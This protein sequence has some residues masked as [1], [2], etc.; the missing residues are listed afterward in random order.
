MY[1]GSS[2]SLCLTATQ[3]VPLL[4]DRLVSRVSAAVLHITLSRPLL[5]LAAAEQGCHFWKVSSCLS[6]TNQSTL[7]WDNPLPKDFHF[8]RISYTLLSWRLLNNTDL[9]V[10]IT[11]MYSIFQKSWGNSTRRSHTVGYRPMCGKREEVN[12]LEIPCRK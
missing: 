5:Q 4:T 7:L 10:V 3:E 2:R 1:V 8:Q 12:F 11:N 6:L 9:V